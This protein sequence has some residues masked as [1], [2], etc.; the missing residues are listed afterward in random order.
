MGALGVLGDLSHAYLFVL[1][2][3]LFLLL[4]AGAIPVRPL[5]FKIYLRQ[6]ID[7]SRLY[8]SQGDAPPS[9]R[10]LNSEFRT[11]LTIENPPVN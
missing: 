6:I 9:N 1:L 5:N 2:L 10:A 8:R 7:E 11:K 3:V 4:V